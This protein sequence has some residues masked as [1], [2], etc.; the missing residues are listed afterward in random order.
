[1]SRNFDLLHQVG[2]MQEPVQELRE[3]ESHTRYRP[4]PEKTVSTPA[5]DMSET[6]R[7]EIGKL[8]HNLFLAPGGSGPRQVIF[9]ATEA[10]AGCTWMCAHVAEVLASLVSGSV[11][12]VD[13]NLRA[14]GLHR[15]FGVEIQDGLSDSLL[16]IDPIFRNVHQLSR[17]NLWLL[18]CASGAGSR[19]PAPE[20]IRSRIAELCTQFDYVLIDVASANTSNDSIVLGDLADGVVVVLK[21][22]SSRREAAR[23]A[24]QELQA[25]Q[26]PILGAVLNQRNFPIP[27]W[28]YNKL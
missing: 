19:Q 5:L 26:I 1:L 21:A 22:D 23:K 11:C 17:A 24:V 10:G 25:A 15:E 18:G 9:T 13:C 3:P 8:V 12:V 14:P 16:E 28:L 2:Q 7:D 20:R 4:V 6:V 27:A